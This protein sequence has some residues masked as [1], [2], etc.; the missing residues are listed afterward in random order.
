METF[1]L[2]LF[3]E[4]SSGPNIEAVPGYATTQACEK[5]GMAWKETRRGW[6]DVPRT[7]ECIPGPVR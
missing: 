3:L 6:N 4:G 7:F 1:V 5:A 2:I